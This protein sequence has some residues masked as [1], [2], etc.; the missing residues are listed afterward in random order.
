MNRIL[1][2]T[3]LVA[4]AVL[5]LLAPAA[6]AAENLGDIWSVIAL[7]G[8]SLVAPQGGT[9][10]RAWAI[11][12]A[13]LGETQLWACKYGDG[14]RVVK[15]F[16][17]YRPVGAVAAC[18]LGFTPHDSE[19]RTTNGPMVFYTEETAGRMVQ[20][21][22]PIVDI[23]PTTDAD[24]TRR[25]Y[26]TA[27][28]DVSVV[29]RGGA[30]TG[31]PQGGLAPGAS[32]LQEQDLAAENLQAGPMANPNAGAGMGTGSTAR[33]VVDLAGAITR[34]IV[35]AREARTAERYAYTQQQNQEPMAEQVDVQMNAAYQA[36]QAQQMTATRQRPM[37]VVVPRPMFIRPGQRFIPRPYAIRRPGGRPQIYVPIPIIRRPANHMP[38]QIP[39]AAIRQMPALRHLPWNQIQQRIQAQHPI[40]R[41]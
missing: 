20:M 23:Y 38:T 36:A 7:Q 29:A 6:R 22:G 14:T 16:N 9:E 32:A 35:A 17:A 34:G 30:E 41:P 4:G 24:P 31:L 18:F 1:R 40:R 2:C 37:S 10:L 27:V 25:A 21:H 28:T 3:L 39:P 26:P 13:M 33:A 12:G 15:R 5:L 11:D 19:A 8:G